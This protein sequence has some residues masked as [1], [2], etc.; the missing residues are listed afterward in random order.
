MSDHRLVEAGGLRLAY[1]TWGDEGGTPVV[2]LHALGKDASD[3]DGPAAA[4][5][6]DGHR[7]YAPDLRGHGSSGWPGVYSF[8]VMRDDV[9]AF[10]DALGLA[11]ADVVGHSM[12]GVVAYL[13]AAS[14]PGRVGRLVLEDV[15]PPLPRPRTVPERPEGPLPFDW[16]M[17]LAIRAQVDDPDPAWLEALGTV[18]APTLVVAGG[19]DSHIPQDRLAEMGRRMPDARVVTIPAGHL[20]H[21]NAPERFAETVV[22]F[23]R[24]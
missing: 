11:V 2:L 22:A 20:V 4:L 1:R 7:V 3:W 16:E 21:E 12:G 24:R 13:L 15:P 8:P 17:V 10:L 5:A 9:A 18:A 19:P 14:H 6:A 23:L